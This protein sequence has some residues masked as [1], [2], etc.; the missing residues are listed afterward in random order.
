MSSRLSTA[1]ALSLLAGMGSAGEIRRA[2]TQS[3]VERRVLVEADLTAKSCKGWWYV[4]FLPLLSSWF[5]SAFLSVSLSLSLSLYLSLS[6]SPSLSLSLLFV[7]RP[8]L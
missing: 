1:L 5:C 4:P 7:V 6:L 8:C 2:A 3:G